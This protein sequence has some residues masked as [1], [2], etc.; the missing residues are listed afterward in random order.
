MLAAR[1]PRWPPTT[2]LEA[3]LPACLLGRLS[4]AGC[5]QGPRGAP[6]PRGCR[7][8]AVAVLSLAPAQGR[9][10]HLTAL[11]HV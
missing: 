4:R 8:E 6:S 9:C 10:P 7:R 5:S 11:A 3:H 2:A 1:Y